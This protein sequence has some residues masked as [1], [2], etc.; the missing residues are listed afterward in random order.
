VQKVQAIIFS[1][2]LVMIMNSMSRYY[3]N[4][5]RLGLLLVIVLIGC[6]NHKGSRAIFKH[7]IQDGPTPWTREPSPSTDSSFTF[8]IISD[9][10]GGEREGIFDI[11]I[12][13]INLFNPA[14]ILSVGD[15]ID[16]GTE[17]V[18]EL[19]AQFN[20]FDE[21]AANAKAPL[22]HVG[23]NHDL[24]NPVMRNYWI[25]RYGKRYYHFVYKDVLFLI[26]D[27]E[28]YDET[29]MQEIYLARARYIE[30]ADG[31]NPELAANAEYLQMPERNL[32]HISG[33]QSSYFEKIIK[34]NDQVRWTFLFMHKPVW[35]KEG[36]GNLSGIEKALANRNYTVINGHVHRYSHTVRNEQDYITLGTT[37]GSQ[38]ADDAYDHITLVS[39]S[40]DG[41]SIANLRMDG[42][43]DKTGKIPLGGEKYCFQAS[44]CQD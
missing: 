14:F 11:A 8:A 1:L 30:L 41:P 23:G 15:L 36:E 9:L 38:T 25:E 4:A 20:R 24:T 31:P 34:E 43:M 32:G 10:N 39:F 22:F 6:Q 26:L 19:E 29:R 18:A 35:K 44:K 16:G 17:D 42:I 28:D 40:N 33:E 27:S 13:Q 5:M 12:Q 37:G 2:F 7:D 21:R 3:F